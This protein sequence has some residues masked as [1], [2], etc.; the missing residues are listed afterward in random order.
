[1]SE[2]S[3]LSGSETISS[4]LKIIG[5]ADQPDSSASIYVLKG[6][7]NF[8][9]AMRIPILAGRPLSAADRPGA[10]R[11]AV[12]NEAFARLGFGNENPLGRSFKFGENSKTLFEVV[13]VARNARYDSLRGDIPPTI[14]VPLAQAMAAT[15]GYGVIFEVRTPGNP[16]QLVPAVRQILHDI[17]SSIAPV[18]ITTQQ[19]VINDS[20]SSERL[21]AGFTAALGGLALLLAAIGLYGTLSYNVSQRTSEIGIRMALGAVAGRV[22]V[23]VIRQTMTVVVIGIVIGVAGSVL[24]TR[25]IS[26]ALLGLSADADAPSMLVGVKPG[27]PMTIAVAAVVLLAVALAAGYLP[28]RRASRIDPIRALRYE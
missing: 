17:D 9:E 7:E 26:A 13:G 5:A 2:V 18:D 25:V 15:P 21:F 16:T 12:V 14:Y 8:L 1:M 20:L 27:D 11:V 19:R 23:Q 28:A 10:P 24:V 22:M 6:K 4:N 3:L